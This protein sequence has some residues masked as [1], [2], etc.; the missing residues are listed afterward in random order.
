MVDQPPR[1]KAITEQYPEASFLQADGFDGAILGVVYGS[2]P[3]RLA[4]SV[5]I[6]LAT[7]MEEGMTYEDAREH[8]DFNIGGGYVGDQTPVWV[9]D[10]EML[11]Y[12]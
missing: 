1:I 10:E 11:L 6:I 8:F 4:Y 3:P 7:L 2:E 5:A 9:E 12:R